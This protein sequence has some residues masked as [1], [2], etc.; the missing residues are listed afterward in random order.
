MDSKEIVKRFE[1]HLQRGA[2]FSLEP[3]NNLNYGL[4]TVDAVITIKIPM[5][6]NTKDSSKKL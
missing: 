4:T 5:L 6:F 1:L 3:N 2:S